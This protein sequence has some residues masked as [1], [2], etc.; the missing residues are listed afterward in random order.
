MVGS[1]AFMPFRCAGKADQ[2]VSLNLELVSR[3]EKSFADEDVVQ[4]FR[5]ETREMLHM[6]E[7]VGERTLE[8]GEA[9]GLLRADVTEVKGGRRWGEG[10]GGGGG[11]GGGASMT[12]ALTKPADGRLPISP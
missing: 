6:G 4:A 11:I 1:S 7:V 8:N 10:G 2:G 12:W 9:V 3:L 5:A